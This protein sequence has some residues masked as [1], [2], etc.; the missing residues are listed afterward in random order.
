MTYKTAGGPI[1]G[2]QRPSPRKRRKKRRKKPVFLTAAQGREIKRLL[3]EG[4]SYGAIKRQFKC[5][6]GTISR[7]QEG[8]WKPDSTRGKSKAPEKPKPEPKPYRPRVSLPPESKAREE[9]Y[10]KLKLAH[11]H[12]FVVG[13]AHRAKVMV[14]R[15][16]Y[17]ANMVID[18]LA[19]V[20]TNSEG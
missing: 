8:T 17:P 3:K 2:Q 12:A 18:L 19:K 7:I 16:E 14:E 1:L 5:S 13:C 10:E 11:E 4:K 9:C 15:K 6:R 20:V